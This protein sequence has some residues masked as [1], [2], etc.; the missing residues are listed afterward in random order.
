MEKISEYFEKFL[1]IQLAHLVK[2]VV[3]KQSKVVSIIVPENSYQAIVLILNKS[4]VRY[5]AYDVEN[6]KFILMALDE[7]LFKIVEEI[8][9]STMSKELKEHI[10]NSIC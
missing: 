5:R 9:N 2:L 1:A 10:L 7:S 3:E 6:F 8:N 4:I